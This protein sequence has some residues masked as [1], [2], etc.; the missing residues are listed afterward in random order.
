MSV[1]SS[2]KQAR[3]KPTRLEH[4]MRVFEKEP[5]PKDKK[6]EHIKGDKLF[7]T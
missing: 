6:G 1:P 5:A 2:K 4:K 7:F 3:V